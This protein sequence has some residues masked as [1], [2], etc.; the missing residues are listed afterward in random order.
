MKGMQKISR[1]QGFRGVLNYALGKNE[2]SL[3][4]GNMSTDDIR[5]LAREF[6]LARRLRPDIK[7]PVWHNSLRLPHDERFLPEKWE[8]IADEYMS[9]MGFTDLNQRCYV[10]HDEPGGQHIHI[11]ASRVGLDGKVYLGKNENLASTRII[12]D[13]ERDFGLK[14]TKGL[15]YEKSGG[16]TRIKSRVSAK[17]RLKKGEIEQALRTGKEPVKQTLQKLITAA[18]EGTPNVVEFAERLIA[19][20]VEVTPNIAK[21]G[22]FNGFNFGMDEIY[23][24]GYQLGGDFKW[25]GLQAK[26][27][28]YEQD[29]D[30]AGLERLRDQI[31]ERPDNEQIAEGTERRKR[32]F[33]Q[34]KP[35]VEPEQR[36]L[37][38][39]G[40]RPPEPTSSGKRKGEPVRNVKP[41]PTKPDKPSRPKT[42]KPKNYRRVSWGWLRDWV[43]DRVRLGFFKR[44]EYAPVDTVQRPV[45]PEAKVN[46]E[47][48]R[49]LEKVRERM[50]M[51]PAERL[52][53]D[54]KEL[55]ARVKKTLR[56]QDS[57][58]QGKR[59]KYELEIKNRPRSPTP[60]V[61]QDREM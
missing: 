51:T 23:Y 10:I 4:G 32:E 25:K 21:T 48:Q 16:K 9:R 43:A 3:I 54:E 30:R 37:E 20:G 28:T 15:E 36:S 42:V 31:G 6:G 52:R 50:R 46:P 39:G 14:I 55:H 60:G 12:S 35:A 17:S 27:V 24:T 38:S 19:A 45:K 7:K 8:K 47:V 61:G 59:E 58:D 26:G 57:A 22:R 29:R 40:M 33:E 44:H 1:G 13:L 41:E 53:H 49:Q 11:V 2:A 5:G 56:E 18:L 34:R